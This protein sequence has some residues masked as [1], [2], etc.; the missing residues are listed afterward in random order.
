MAAQGTGYKLQEVGLQC[1]AC[2]ASCRKL[3]TAVCSWLHARQLRVA[4]PSYTRLQVT[5]Q[6]GF[7][8]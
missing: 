8:N 5:A 4:A 2:A 7:S 6:K 3:A 1:G